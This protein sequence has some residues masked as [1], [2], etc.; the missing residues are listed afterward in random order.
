MLSCDAISSTIKT[1]NKPR[2]FLAFFLAF[3][4][5]S[6]LVDAS[7]TAYAG[8]EIVPG[9]GSDSGSA[10]GDK[11]IVTGTGSDSGSAIGDKEI[12]PGTGSDSGSSSGDKEIVP[13]TGSSSG[14]KVNVS[15]TGSD[16][17]SSTGDTF[18]P[19]PGVNL[20]IVNNGNTRI[21]IIRVPAQVQANLNRVAN[22]ILNQAAP[23]N[24][25][26]STIKH[27][28]PGGVNTLAATHHVQSSIV[29]VGVSPSTATALVNSLNGLTGET[30]NV[31]IYKFNDAVTAYNQI[32]NESSPEVI[33]G[34]GHNPEF[35]TINNLLRQFRVPLNQP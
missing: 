12:V 20:Q 17:V 2:F 29:R 14:D 16:S 30:Q 24:S 31:N 21:P 10:I 19:A 28:L 1:M 25:P 3:T 22:H 5:L 15:G 7:N 13:G 18:R 4:V 11:E 23:A 26:L 34:L 8:K 6:Y 27:I 32:L 9:I 35:L 33:Q